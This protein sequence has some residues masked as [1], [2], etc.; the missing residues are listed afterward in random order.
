MRENNAAE[1]GR[2]VVSDAAVER[3]LVTAPE[4]QRNTAGLNEHG[5]FDLLALPAQSL[6]ERPS[7]LHV[8]HAQCDQTDPLI[9]RLSFSPPASGTRWR[10]PGT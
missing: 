7:A 4:D 3:E 9:H 5:F 10:M 2:L 1:A 6:V 8:S